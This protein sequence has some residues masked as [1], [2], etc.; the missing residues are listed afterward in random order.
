MCRLSVGVALL[1]CLAGCGVE[2]S[3]SG[4]DIV[5]SNPSS[6]NQNSSNSSQKTEDNVTTKTDVNSSVSDTNVTDSNTNVDTNT[7]FDA[8]GAVYDAKACGAFDGYLAMHDNSFDPEPV[9]DDANGMVLASSM[10]LGFNPKDAEIT[11]YYSPLTVTKEGAL[12]SVFGDGYY[13]SFDKGWVQNDR[14]TIYI[15]KPTKPK[16]SCYRYELNSLIASDI[17]KTKVYR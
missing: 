14:K 5:Y 6:N 2:T 13:F 1:F 9:K 17:N 8:S 10:P 16:Q 12:I 7:T 3:S 11:E 4:G 15:K